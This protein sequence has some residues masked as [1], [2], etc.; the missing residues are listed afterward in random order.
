MHIPLYGAVRA[1][2][3]VRAAGAAGPPGADVS[4]QQASSGSVRAVLPAP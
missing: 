1:A 3:G 2:A 4:P